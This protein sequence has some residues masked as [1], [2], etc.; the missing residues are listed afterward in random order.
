MLSYNNMLYY[1]NSS[2]VSVQGPLQG[3]VPGPTPRRC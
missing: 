3:R 2:I 1:A